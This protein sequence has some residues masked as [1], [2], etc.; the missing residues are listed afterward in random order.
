[1]KRRALLQSATALAAISAIQSMQAGRAQDSTPQP[2]TPDSVAGIPPIR[3]TLV[4]I[5]ADEETLVPIDPNSFTMQFG[6]NGRVGIQADCNSA[7]GT[8]AIEGDAFSITDVFTTLAMCSEDSVDQEFIAAIQAATTFSISRDPGDQ[9]ALNLDEDGAR[10]LLNP[11]L[12]GVVWEW[13]EFL[14]GDG[15]TITPNAPERYTLEFFDDDR[16]LVRADC[17]SGRGEVVLDGSAIDLTVATT[18]KMCA[19]DSSFNDFVRVLGEASEWLIVEGDLYLN[20]PM[21]AGGA[22]FKAIPPLID[23]G[24]TP[25][26]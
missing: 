7:V 22:R 11:S 4:S 16:V 25:L 21:D 19:K 8:Y 3:W 23:E 17:N 14:S 9:L 13:Q 5:D 24:A 15:T 18:K 20:L 2:G 12:V 26:P 6:L 10:V 1:M